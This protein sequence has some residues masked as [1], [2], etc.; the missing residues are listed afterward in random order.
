M[1]NPMNHNYVSPF[2]IP[3]SPISNDLG[4]PIVNKINVEEIEADA[5]HYV[6]TIDLTAYVHERKIHH[7]VFYKCEQY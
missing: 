7:A 4:S 6:E 5:V 1:L 3:K 2:I